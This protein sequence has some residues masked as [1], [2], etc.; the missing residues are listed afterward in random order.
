MQELMHT[1]SISEGEEEDSSTSGVKEVW[2]N[3]NSSKVVEHSPPHVTAPLTI[4]DNLP[5]RNPPRNRKPPDRL[6]Y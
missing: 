1:S 5:K 2:S 4:S 6:T 3:S